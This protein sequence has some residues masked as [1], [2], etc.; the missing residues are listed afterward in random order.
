MT[1]G[2]EFRLGV[3]VEDQSGFSAELTDAAEMA[4]AELGWRHRRVDTG[5]DEE[6]VDVVLAIGNVRLFPDLLR[7]PK[8]ARRVLWHGETLPRPTAESGTRVHQLVP[9]GRLLDTG[10]SAL[11]GA[12]RSEPLMRLREQAAIVRE[13]LAN[14]RLLEKWSGAF[15]RIVIDSRDRAEGAIRAGLDVTVVP[16]GYHESYAGPFDATSEDRPIGALLLAH[17]VGRYGRRQRLVAELERSFDA[18]QI[19]LTKV[20]RG[21]YGAERGAL[22]RQARVVI[23]VH[24]VP[25][26]HPGFRWIVASAAGAVV[27]T[28]PLAS[29]EPLVRDVH[30]VEAKA[31]EMP[32]AVAEIL[33]D[34]PRRKRIVDASQSLLATDLAMC[35]VLP[36]V[37]GVAP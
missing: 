18:R 22:L 12:R 5:A 32:D 4:A 31:D 24:R 20:T 37:L 36:R 21:T 2:T 14:L 19:A 3:A 10:F 17:L 27:V 28:E 33:A 9:T 34:E 13:P 15:D 35:R 16:Y 25:G 30:Y 23:D 11:P 8:S 26:N 6:A 1:A 7:R 29:P